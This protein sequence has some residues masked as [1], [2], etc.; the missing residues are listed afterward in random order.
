MISIKEAIIV[1]GAYDK[2]K[3]DR[4]VDATI[5]TTNGFRIYN[6]REK[7]EMIR[8]F[9][10]TTGIIIL[11]DSDG[12]GFRIRN[13]V[14]NIVGNKNVKHAYIPDVE[15]K[16]KRKSAPSKEGFLGVEGIDDE[17]ILTA[18]KNAGIT[19][20]E[21]GEDER[22]ITKA[23]L[24]ADGLSG[25]A[26][27]KHLREKLFKKLNL[28]FKISSNMMLDVLNDLYGYDEYTKMIDE[29]KKDISL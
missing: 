6:D 1:E 28:P 12:A 18:L 20:K 22:T 8:R 15:G 10:E 7:A 11:T 27:S 21:R 9:A 24:F 3:L 16:E 5:I 29:I 2:I 26:S 19:Q 4:L 13:Y 14:K 25:G 23:D 17:T